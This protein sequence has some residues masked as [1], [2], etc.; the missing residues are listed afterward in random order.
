MA[1]PL[2]DALF[3]PHHGKSTPFLIAPDGTVT[4]HDDFLKQAARLAHALMAMGLQ[5]GDRLA[6]QV[7]KTEAAL[8]LYAAAVQSGVVFLPLNSA[9]TVD[10][11]AI[12]LKIAKRGWWF[13]ISAWKGN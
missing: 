2:Y 10:D 11:S 13:A 12:S 4:S 3:A 5:P 6:V 9:Y 7:E 1:N 8:A